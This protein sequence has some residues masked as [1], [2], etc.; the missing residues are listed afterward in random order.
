MERGLSFTPLSPQ[1]YRA[2]PRGI[3][4]HRRTEP[5]RVPSI[6]GGRDGG[7]WKER[8]PRPP[9]TASGRARA[10][11]PSRD[12]DDRRRRTAR[13]RQGEG[14]GSRRDA[15]SRRLGRE[16]HGTPQDRRARGA[17]HQHPADTGRRARVARRSPRRGGDRGA[18]RGAAPGA[19]ARA[20]R[21]HGLR[22]P[23]WAPR[24]PAR[25]CTLLSGPQNRRDRRLPA[26]HRALR[27]RPGAFTARSCA[28]RRQAGGRLVPGEHTRR[29]A[30][31]R[32][33][34]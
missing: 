7:E 33:A 16:P 12:A 17:A 9:L 26:R 15:R 18:R 22:L 8:S 25:R 32:P 11:S 30:A 10:P 3:G 21:R 4:I 29:S 23:E 24:D 1:W 20:S 13:A 31:V 19:P 27:A 5:P 34:K 2:H 14:G 6:D 28:A